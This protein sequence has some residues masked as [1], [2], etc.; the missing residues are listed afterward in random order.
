MPQAPFV[1]VV[2]YG[3][4]PQN[5]S[6]EQLHTVLALV[7]RVDTATHCVV[8]VSTTLITRVADEFI[9]ELLRGTNLLD[10]GEDF[11]RRFTSSYFGHADKGV[12]AA[13]RDLVKRYREALNPAETGL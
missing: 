9:A 10:G 1:I 5:T 3:K 8:D 13:Y 11:I 6:A 2:G 4:F 12:L 7:A